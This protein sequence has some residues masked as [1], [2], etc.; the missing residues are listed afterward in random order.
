MNDLPYVAKWF[1][2]GPILATTLCLIAM[3]GTNYQA[4]IGSKIDW[5]G[6][7]VSYIGLPLFILG[8]LSYKIVKRSKMVPLEECDFSRE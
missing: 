1:P 5:Y 4:F 2:L 7:A 6:I 3:L 8:Y